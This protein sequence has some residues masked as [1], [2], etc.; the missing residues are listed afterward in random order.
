LHFANVWQKRGNF[1]KHWQIRLETKAALRVAEAPQGNVPPA[2]AKHWQKPERLENGGPR[3][4][5]GHG[6]DGGKSPRRTEET[7]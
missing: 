6:P 4:Q 2:L 5:N 3:T 7:P 1:A